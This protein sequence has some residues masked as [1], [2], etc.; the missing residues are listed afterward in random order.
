MKLTKKEQAWFKRLQK[1]LDAAPESLTNKISSYTIGDDDVTVYDKAKLKE[2][3]NNNP[4]V[5]VEDYLCTSVDAADAKIYC[6]EFPF[7]VEAT[8]G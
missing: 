6:L 1:C 4:R 5:E 2:Y 7:S 3:F 8:S